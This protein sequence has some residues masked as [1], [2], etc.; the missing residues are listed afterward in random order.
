MLCC[1]ACSCRNVEICLSLYRSCP[2][3]ILAV[4]GIVVSSLL[5]PLFALVN[6]AGREIALRD[7]LDANPISTGN[8][9][10]VGGM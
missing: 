5:L 10:I 3:L 4:T 1:K 9:M 2:P 6:R 8:A 7:R